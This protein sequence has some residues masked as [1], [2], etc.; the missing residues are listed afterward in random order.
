[1][2]PQRSDADVLRKRAAYEDNAEELFALLHREA[3]KTNAL[4]RSEIREAVDFLYYYARQN[5]A[6][7]PRAAFGPVFPIGIFRSR[8]LQGRFSGVGLG[9]V[10]PKPAEQTGLIRPP[11]R[12][13]DD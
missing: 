2:F 9:N 7:Q 1:M 10:L 12:A 8:S 4:G 6:N 3:G 13:I 5:Q 11:R